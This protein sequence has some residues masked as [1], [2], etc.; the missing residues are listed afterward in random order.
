MSELLGWDIGGAH[1][2]LARMDCDGALRSL[3]QV[4]CP[5]WQGLQALDVALDAVLTPEDLTG[6]CRHA[7]TM[8]GELVDAFEDRRQGVLRLVEHLAHRLGAPSIRLFAGTLGFLAV[9][10]VN[11]DT[12]LQI[13]SANWLA[14]GCWVGHRMPRALLIDIGSTTTDILR[15]DGGQP[16]PGAYSDRARLNAGELVY[17]GVLRTPVMSLVHQVPLEGAWTPCMAEFFSTTADVY[18]LTGELNEADDHYPPADGGPKTVLGSA[19]RLG[20]QFGLD[21]DPDQLPAMRALARYLREQQ[22][23]QLSQQIAQVTSCV[24]FDASV[25][26]VAAGVG[27]FLLEALAA[28]YGTSFV[29]FEALFEGQTDG[30]SDV[31]PAAAVAALCHAA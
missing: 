9:E 30:A 7:I 25:P 22:L 1:L 18:R 29:A 2:K 31:A 11:K 4:P 8:T 6:K 26:W 19:R 24:H 15:I 12:A 10:E 3:Q 27:R 23:N 21:V 20:R 17:T 5:L 14:S 28:R 13:A 16:C